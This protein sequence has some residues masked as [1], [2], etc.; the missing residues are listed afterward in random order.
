MSELLTGTLEHRHQPQYQP[1]RI[2]AETTRE[3]RYRERSTWR[4]RTNKG[5]RN[6]KTRCGKLNWPSDAQVL[7]GDSLKEKGTQCCPTLQRSDSR[8]VICWSGRPIQLQNER[9]WYRW[10]TNC[11]LCSRT[12]TARREREKS[13]GLGSPFHWSARCWCRTPGQPAEASFSD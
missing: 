3:G 4:R 8:E 7:E 2:R 13:Q 9:R 5:A 12:S 11:R 6:G 1:Y 10:S